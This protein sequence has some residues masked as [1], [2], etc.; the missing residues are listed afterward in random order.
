M[1]QTR[2]WRTK[3]SNHQMKEGREQFKNNVSCK[4]RGKKSPLNFMYSL[5]MISNT[6]S[7]IRGVSY[8]TSYK[9]C[10]QRAWSCLFPLIEW[11]VWQLFTCWWAN[12]SRRNEQSCQSKC[13]Q[14]LLQDVTELCSVWILMQERKPKQW[15]W[16]KNTVPQLSNKTCDEGFW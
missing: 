5:E 12:L 9:S 13:T 1:F 11:S 8:N 7:N 10:Q 3:V 4:S 6:N 15:Q 16:W 14:F 2:M